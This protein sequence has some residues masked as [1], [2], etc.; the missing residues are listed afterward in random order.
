[1]DI[2]DARVAQRSEVTVIFVAGAGID[3]QMPL[4]GHSLS[5]RIRKRVEC[6]FP[7]LFVAYHCLCHIIHIL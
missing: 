3:A 2:G 1:M 7:C 6:F 5:G 4:E